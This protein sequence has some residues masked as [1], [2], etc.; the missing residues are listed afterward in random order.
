MKQKID[1][2]LTLE[3]DDA[4]AV[5]RAL[6]NL[7]NSKLP[8][9]SKPEK[10]KKLKEKKKSKPKKR[11]RPKGSKNQPKPTKLSQEF[12]R[13]INGKKILPNHL[14]L[15]SIFLANE[16]KNTLPTAK[17][18]AKE[19]GVTLNLAYSFVNRH[20]VKWTKG[21]KRSKK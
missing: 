4:I 18:A 1:I 8:K 9:K 2:S 16:G 17:E 12:R 11:G 14:G 13:T 7:S 3:G 15:A 6:G 10:V 5:L 19:A 20:G 21:Y